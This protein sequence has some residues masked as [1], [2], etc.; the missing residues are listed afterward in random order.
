[1][2]QS[3]SKAINLPPLILTHCFVDGN[4]D[5]CRYS[6]YKRRRDEQNRALVQHRLN[7]LKKRKRT[8]DNPSSNNNKKEVKICQTS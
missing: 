6:I 5:L 7:T 4:I 8:K 3:L 1:M 2:G